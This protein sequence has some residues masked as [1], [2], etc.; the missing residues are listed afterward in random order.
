MA[1]LS[2]RIPYEMPITE[3][4]LRKVEHAEDI[5]F[6][7]GFRIV[8]ARLYDEEMLRIE[9]GEDE[10]PKAI[11]MREEIISHLK[12]LGVRDVLIDLKGYRPQVPR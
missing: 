6:S 5:I 2:S 12:P 4:M 11:A 7:M 8:R 3:R 1:C 10:I 9:V